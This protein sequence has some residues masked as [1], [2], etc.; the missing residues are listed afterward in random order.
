ME[1][2]MSAS[3]RDRGR[4]LPRLDPGP[5]RSA[6]IGADDREHNRGQQ[7]DRENRVCHHTLAGKPATDARARAV[8][9]RQKHERRD[10]QARDDDSTPECRVA[11]QFLQARENPGPLRG[12]SAKN[13]GCRIP[14]RP[15]PKKSPGTTPPPRRG[16]TKESP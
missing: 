12:I 5:T 4:L 8:E 13:R 2:F 10:Q 6:E 7:A 3:L 1:L 9:V 11:D 16:G 15:N 14:P